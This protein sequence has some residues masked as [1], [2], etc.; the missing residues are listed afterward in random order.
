MNSAS[1]GLPAGFRDL[2]FEEARTRRSIE[3]I[4]GA[5]FAEQGYREL[6]P[7]SVELLDVYGRG[8]QHVHEEAIKFI[9]RHDQ[10]VA[11]RADFTPAVARIVASRFA[12]LPGPFRIWYAGD[13]FRKVDR[14]HTRFCEFGQIGAELIEFPGLE[15]DQEI[16]TLA[17]RLLDALGLQDVQIHLNHASIFGGLIRELGLDR[18]GASEVRSEIGRKDTR[19]LARRLEELGVSAEIRRQ[20]QAL[21]MC[22]G[23]LEVL[24]EA[25][26]L[27][28]NEESCS[29]LD[30]LARLAESLSGW[31][32]RIVYDLTE[33]D[34]M[35]Y[36]TGIMVTFFSPKLRSELGKGGR[37]DT[38]L[39]AFGRDAPAVGF[40]F[41]MDRLA[42]LR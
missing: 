18:Q 20:V 9:D 33:V 8:N 4:L 30:Q 39:G 34:E 25:R 15:G 27:L 35:E 7:P 1:P 11:L 3:A 5:I 32:E 22:I 13:V 42:E 37:Y 26:T 6:S 24:Q 28:K 14:H 2:L 17:I 29:A 19:G 36:Y 12:A 23:G 40:S 31:S 38:L 21:T 10:L 16:L 41:S